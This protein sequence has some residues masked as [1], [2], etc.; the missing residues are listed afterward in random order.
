MKAGWRG[1][2][3]NGERP[4]PGE[5]NVTGCISQWFTNW[6]FIPGAPNHTNV[7]IAGDSAL[8][9]YQKTCRSTEAMDQQVC[10]GMRSN[11]W[12]A[13]GTAAVWS[14]CGVDGGNPEGCPKGNPEGGNCAPGGY[15]HGPDARQLKTPTANPA[16]WVAGGVAE[17]AFGITANHGGGYSY[18]LCP[19]PKEGRT[20]L[21]E[22][23]FQH[24]PL[25]F[26]GSTQWLQWNDDKENRTAIPAVRTDT[27]TFPAG[28][29]WTRNPI[30]AC[31]TYEGG[32]YTENGFPGHPAS[33]CNGSQFEPPLPG[34]TGFYGE[35]PTN[36]NDPPGARRSLTPWSVVD[37]VQVP[38]DLPE[39][40][41]V[42]GFRIDCEQTPQIWQHCA[43]V[44][45]LHGV[46]SLSE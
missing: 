7:T 4:H 34:L 16:Q 46:A 6:T 42:V 31:G 35:T 2:G 19:F 32:G 38:H 44:R 5:E 13:P 18:R 1:A 11:P 45:V 10:Q 41:Y 39:G 17:V 33:F 22:E 14:P 20:A 29:Q 21:T 12:R 36:K 9:T 27:G 37:Q 24:T 43:D 28:S 25:R 40:D 15:G 23:C 30:P 26:V 3:C 8:G